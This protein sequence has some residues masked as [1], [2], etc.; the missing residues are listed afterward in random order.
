[1]TQLRHDW[2]TDRLPDEA[3]A[4]DD[5]DVCV[6]DDADTGA[7]RY[8]TWDEVMLGTAWHHTDFWRPQ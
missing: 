4:D 6:L 7:W 2:I 1:M 3:D 5:L 8:V